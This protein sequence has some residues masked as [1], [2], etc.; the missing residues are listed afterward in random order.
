MGTEAQQLRV[1]VFPL[2]TPGH[3]QPAV[4]IAKLLATEGVITYI[5]TTP[6]HVPRIEASIQRLPGARVETLLVE[7]P[8]L[9]HGMPE[10]LTS[11]T[12]ADM[13]MDFI[14]STIALRPSFEL[15]VKQHRPNAIISD[16]FYP[17]TVDVAEE[18]AIPRL[19]FLGTSFFS[20]CVDEELNSVVADGDRVVLERLP[21]RIAFDAAHI[22]DPGQM[23]PDF[24]KLFGW[25]MQAQ[26]KSYGV[27]VNSFYALEREYADYYRESLGKK[28]WHIGPVFLRDEPVTDK[29]DLKGLF[30]WLDAK[31]A[32]SVLYVCFG[33]LSRFTEAQQ[34]ELALGL[35]SSGH[36]FIWVARKEGERLSESGNGLIIS[37]W[38]PQLLVLN[39][40][41]VGGFLTHCGW[42]SCLES[43]VAGVP[44]LTWPMFAD[45]FFNEKLVVEVLKVGVDIGVKKY[46]LRE[47]EREEVKAEDI[48]AAIGRLMGESVEAEEMRKRARELREAARRAVEEGGSSRKDLARMIQDLAIKK[49]EGKGNI[50]V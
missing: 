48:S 28:A 10:D 6:A 36:P 39:H 40:S 50:P 46:S 1:F 44:M 41:S 25:I 15:L 4:D 22:P 8:S 42:N 21:H 13:H 20:H 38:A 29:S 19:M 9:S 12:S 7:W 14:L 30:Q 18:N 16:F 24:G 17:W 31:P 26:E 3:L 49:H 34:R 23:R 47:D 2:M 27:V 5:V 45:Q 35:E 11:V 37:G 33:S 32:R 43:V